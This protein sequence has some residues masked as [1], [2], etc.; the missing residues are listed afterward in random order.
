MVLDG[1]DGALGEQRAQGE[2]H[3][4]A[5]HHLL[6]GQCGDPREPAA[7]EGGVERNGSVPGLDE[8]LV[9][10]LE[11]VRRGDHA[12][13]GPGGGDLVAVG[14]GGSHHLGHE[15]TDL[16]QHHVQRL[17]IEFA[18]SVGREDVIETD[19]LVEHELQRAERW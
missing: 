17:G 9:G 4:A 12:T 7:A 10:L 19:D 5:G 6:D 8:L 18:E 13:L 16:F 14:V 15:T 3:V 1:V 2:G 11:R